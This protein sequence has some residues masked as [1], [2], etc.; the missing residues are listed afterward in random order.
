M[1]T[2]GAKVGI[3]C[4]NTKFIEEYLLCIVIFTIFADRITN[5]KTILIMKQVFLSILILLL[6]MVANAYDIAVENADGV[7]IYYNYTNN[8][9][10]LAVTSGGVNYEYRGNV[11]IPDEV[12]YMN[13]TRKVTSIGE[14]AFYTCYDLTSV[15][16]PNSVISIGKSAFYKCSDLKS[17]T[18][19][20]G[21]VTID[22]G[23]FGGCSRLTS[24][25]IPNSV[26]F[27]GKSAFSG[28]K[29]LTTATISNNI[30]SIEDGL[31]S[32]CK[33]LT[34]L[35]IPDKVTFIGNSAFSSCNSLATVNIPYN[36]T[37]IGE[38][39]FYGCSGLESLTIGKGITSIGNYA[40]YGADIPT[41]V[42]LIDKPFK[43]DGTTFSNNT[44]INA[45]L[46]VP[47]GSIDKYKETEGWKDFLYIEEG[48][49]PNG[50]G[51]KCAKPTISVVDGKLKFSCETDEVEYHYIISNDSPASGEGNNVAFSQKYTVSVYASKSGYENSDTAT[52]EITAT[53]GLTG[54]ANGDGVVD[55][56]DVVK[57]TNIIMGE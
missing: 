37:F 50:G 44:Y 45:T 6:P 12:T 52:A 34:S 32:G 46:Y 19:P 36:V 38:Y 3:I 57:V 41:I 33:N 7:T 16:V 2:H 24:I 48:T 23:A 13:R 11:V 8:N 31:F 42:S 53:V 30:T 26:T 28:C 27:I 51:Q 40:F 20:N 43:I 17:I 15:T 9:T 47:A 21:I 5:N 4:E 29:K 10:E 14:N 35:T 55:A 54:D 18:I 56:A 25:T 49:G 22:E 1:K 39:A